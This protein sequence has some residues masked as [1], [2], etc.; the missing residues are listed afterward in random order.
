M[1]FHKN[2]VLFQ[3][4][5]LCSVLCAQT[6]KTIST[7]EAGKHIG[8]NATVCGQVASAHFAATTRGRPT[9]LNLDQPYPNQVFTVLIWGSDRNTFGVPEV[10][11]RDKRICAKGT[12]SSYK[13]VPEIVAREPG[14][15]T[16]QASG[17]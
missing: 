9:F 5:V 13:G 17:R 3:V 12:I 14:Q 8:E 4:T 7:S 15:I 2:L 1:R 16:V 6:V 10:T 11:Y